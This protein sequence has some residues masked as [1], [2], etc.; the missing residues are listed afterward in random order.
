MKSTGCCLGDIASLMFGLRPSKCMLSPSHESFYSLHLVISVWLSGLPRQLGARV[1]LVPPVALFPSSLYPI[2][3]WWQFLNKFRPPFGR[4]FLGIDLE[5]KI[6]IWWLCFCLSDKVSMPTSMCNNLG[7]FE[8][9]EM[10]L[11][12]SYCAY[13]LVQFLAQGAGNFR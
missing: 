12:Y 5:C 3:I 11:A 6:L 10:H 13:V 4:Y 1:A 2:C 9:C 7:V 8:T